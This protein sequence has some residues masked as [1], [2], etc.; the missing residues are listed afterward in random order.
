MKSTNSNPL[1]LET[2]WGGENHVE[3]V[4][5]KVFKKITFISDSIG[6]ENVEIIRLTWS[7][8]EFGLRL[9]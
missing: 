8:V 2:W 4:Y 1:R 5:T 6:C 9:E 3:K 7:K